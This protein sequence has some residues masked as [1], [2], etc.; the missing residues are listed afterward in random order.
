[1]PVVQSGVGLT[2]KNPGLFRQDNFLGGAPDKE[3]LFNPPP[4]DPTPRH[5]VT[6]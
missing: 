6:V 2:T 3:R 4:T 5:A 1:M